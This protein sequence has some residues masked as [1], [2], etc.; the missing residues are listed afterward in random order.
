MCREDFA[1]VA[2]C[3]D[4]VVNEAALMVLLKGQLERE[5][6]DLVCPHDDAF[7]HVDRMIRDGVF[8]SLLR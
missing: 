3:S 7:P 2:G 5:T 4:G 8:S 6:R 1:A